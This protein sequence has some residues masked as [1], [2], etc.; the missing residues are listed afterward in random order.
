[1]INWCEEVEPNAPSIT[2]PGAWAMH[3]YLG[4]LFASQSEPKSWMTS[5]KI[6]GISQLPVSKVINESGIQANIYQEHA[7]DRVFWQK[8]GWSY[9]LS[10]SSSSQKRSEEIA[11]D[12]IRTI[13]LD[14]PIPGVP[15]GTIVLSQD[16]H[17]YTCVEWQSNNTYYTLT[18]YDN[19]HAAIHMAN[20]LVP[21][22]K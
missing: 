13:K 11:I 7:V 8:N 2:R 18:W 1:M 9:L 16:N 10:F 3:N 15:S 19:P 5:E 21:V 17:S 22:P 20:S 4:S 6:K 14:P 12:L